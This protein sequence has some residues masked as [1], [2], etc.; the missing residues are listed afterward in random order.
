MESETYAL[1]LIVVV[2]LKL[3]GCP[4][5]VVRVRMV[6]SKTTSWNLCTIIGFVIAI[7]EGTIHPNS[8]LFHLQT[9]DLSL[10]KLN[11]GSK[12]QLGYKQLTHLNFLL[13]IL[14]LTLQ[15]RI[16]LEISHLMSLTTTLQQI[17][18]YLIMM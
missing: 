1:S 16:P 10:I 5:S 2:K 15:G 18:S 6:A 3:V 13:F 11:S 14:L 8:S 9:L 4:N 17:P 12:F 7:L